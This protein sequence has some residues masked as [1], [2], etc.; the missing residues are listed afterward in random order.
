[1]LAY[2]LKRSSLYFPWRQGFLCH[3]K[4]SKWDH[5]LIHVRFL[6]FSECSIHQIVPHGFFRNYSGHRLTLMGKYWQRKNFPWY[7]HSTLKFI[8]EGFIASRCQYSLIINAQVPETNYI[9]NHG[10][11]G[12]KCVKWLKPS[13]AQVTEN[14]LINSRH[15]SLWKRKDNESCWLS[16]S[17]VGIPY[18][19]SSSNGWLATDKMRGRTVNFSSGRASSYG[20]I[21]SWTQ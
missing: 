11:S 20:K 19:G 7:H 4:N 12:M 3:D 5:S 1:M 2:F 6:I 21:S 13:M 17:L 14:Y 18:S 9:E 8:K 16:L 15:Y 10:H